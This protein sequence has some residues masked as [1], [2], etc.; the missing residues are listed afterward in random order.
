VSRFTDPLPSDRYGRGMRIRTIALWVT[1]ALA[2]IAIA[3]AVSIAASS[4]S[5]QRIGI[6]SEPLSAGDKLAP[7]IAGAKE[8][9][10]ARTQ[11]KRKRRSRSSEPRATTNTPPP[12]PVQTT[13]AA[14]PSG[15]LG[16][17][18]GGG[19]GSGKGRGGGDD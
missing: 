18:H 10:P 13:P 5:S 19:S 9:Q 6:S 2:G 4:L 17:D 11:R 12:A 1:L 14:P 3:A 15:E 8:T 7:A 16:D